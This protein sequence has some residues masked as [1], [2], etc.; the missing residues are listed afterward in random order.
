MYSNIQT[1][2]SAANHFWSWNTLQQLVLFQMLHQNVHLWTHGK[3]LKWMHLSAKLELTYFCHWQVWPSLIVDWH[4][5][6]IY[7]HYPSLKSYRRKIFIPLTIV[8]HKL[9]FNVL[10]LTYPNREVCCISIL[11]QYNLLIWPKNYTASQ[12]SSMHPRS[13]TWMPPL[14]TSC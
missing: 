3:H 7:P 5:C 12:D 4:S 9:N 2:I 11:H 14:W 6:V 13:V 8:L 1:V 10:F